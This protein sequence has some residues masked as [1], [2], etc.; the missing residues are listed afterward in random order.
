[1]THLADDAVNILLVDDQ[2]GKLLGYQA[3]LEGL[4]QNLLLASNG[5]EALEHLLKNDVAVIL[6]DVCMPEQD[7]FELVELIRQHHRFRDT[8][9][10]FVSAVQMTEVDLIK[11]YR[12]GA[13]DYVSV[14]IIPE[15]LRAKVE[16]F[17]DLHRKTRAL[18][19]LNIGLETRVNE[20]TAELQ[21]SEARFR[22]MADTIP[23]LIW[24]ADRE[25]NLSY[26]N[27][28]FQQY[29]G[30]TAVR[31]G[32]WLFDSIHPEDRDR[33]LAAWE[34]AIATATPLEIE[35]RTRSQDGVYRWYLTRALPQI[36]Q[37]GGPG[38]WFGVSTD[39]ELQKQAEERI[40]D[41]ERLYKAIGDSLDFGIW[42]SDTAGRNLYTSNSFLNLLGITQEECA[43]GAW[44]ARI[45]DKGDVAGVLAC[46]E[47]MRD[48]EPFSRELW[49]RGADGHE[50]PVLSRGVPIKDPEGNVISWVGINLDIAQMKDAELS[51]RE[52]DR[53]KDEFLAT[54]AHELRN[55]LAPIRS[56]LDLMRIKGDDPA[57]LRDLRAMLERQV[58]QMV[59][60]VDDLLDVSRITRGVLTLQMSET[61]LSD[62]VRASV[63]TSMPG[64]AS[65]SH[66]LKINLPKKP[67]MLWADATRLA[68]VLGNLLNNAARYTPPSGSI[69]IDAEIEGSHAVVRVRDNGIGFEPEKAAEIFDMFTQVD[70]DS[71]A[72]GGLGIGLTLAKRLIELHDGEIRASS[73][74]PDL[75]STFEVRIPLAEIASI[76][77]KETGHAA[78]A[79][80]ALRIVIADDNEDAAYLL[81][82]MLTALGHEVVVGNCGLEAV[83]LVEEFGPHVAI[84][85]I[86]MPNMNGFEAARHIRQEVW[87]QSVFLIALTGWGQPE[88]RRQT[89]EAGFNR[90][91]TKPADI[92]HLTGILKDD[93]REWSA[94]D[95]VSSRLN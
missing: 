92:Q 27:E 17:I 22:L 9:V 26:A 91:L 37:D 48:G 60:L 30:E 32:H 84:L 16:V 71:R 86:G 88:D 72:S 11:G 95:S 63:E 3:I 57:T 14:P 79:G 69:S 78:L 5:R 56:G 25:G 46:E 87:G 31:E 83:R 50:H 44:T 40:K 12:S 23:S 36:E 29:I 47:A 73:M 1:M 41:S 53:R 90:H 10:I 70:K 49:L 94:K 59:R 19:R 55:P 93:F 18:E 64:I 34:E 66:E 67:L 33:C 8:A 38:A 68:Q 61:N 51:L 15:I 13:V 43:E 45:I 80:E 62:V 21:E 54:L 65:K 85:D 42:I 2:P 35:H 58:N 20:R 6:M 4:G 74:G 75:G 24:T 52:A 28:R 81:K 82:L 76:R 39:I 89:M 7:G 77:P